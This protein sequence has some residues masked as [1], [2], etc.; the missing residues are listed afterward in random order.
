MGHHVVQQTNV[1]TRNDNNHI[2]RN[3]TRCFNLNLL[4]M[5]YI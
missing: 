3:Y 2:L 4:P 1:F 5:S